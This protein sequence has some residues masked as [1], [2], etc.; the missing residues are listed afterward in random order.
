MK[1]ICVREKLLKSFNLASHIVS[2]NISLPILGNF[3]IETDTNKLKISAT[4]LETAISVWVSGKTES[5]GKVCVPASVLTQAVS[6]LQS[7]NVE[8]EAVEKYN[9]KISS[10]D[11]EGVIRGNPAD[12]FP[13]IPSVQKTYSVTLPVSLLK[14]ALGQLM[15]I[16]TISETRP[17]ISGVL[18]SF[19]KN[20]LKFVATDSF[21]LG[22]KTIIFTDK[23]SKVSGKESLKSFILPLKGVSELLKTLDAEKD[24]VSI[25]YDENQALFVLD[26]VHLVSRLIGGQFPDYE[27]I[28]PSEFMTEVLVNKEELIKKIKAVSI[29]SSRTND[30]KLEMNSKDQ[31]IIMESASSDTGQSKSTISCSITGDSAQITFNWRYLL[32]GLMNLTTDQAILRFNTGQKPALFRGKGDKSYFY[33]VMPIRE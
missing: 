14:E 10:S 11:F 17:E 16:I 23:S 28:I 6:N 8:L 9:I 1:F 27:K 2:K 21:R 26:G 4:N 13:A 5:E 7:D 25:F 29:F 22:E 24:V 12:D 19:A 33:L 15:N 3:L 31:K 32:D 18:F 20:Q 30:I